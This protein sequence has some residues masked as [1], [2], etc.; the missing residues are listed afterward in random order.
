MTKVID[1][2]HVLTYEEWKKRPAVV[3]M[4]RTAPECESCNGDGH[5]ECNCGNDH[6]CNTCDGTGKTINYRNEYE[7]RLRAEIRNLQK[8]ILG[9]PITQADDMLRP[10]RCQT[11][12]FFS[13]IPVIVRL[14]IPQGD[15]NGNSP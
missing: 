13:D 4:L 2:M 11:A 3:E 15:S 12:D 1:G 9:Q 10:D 7:F 5:H 14:F 6:E 8:W